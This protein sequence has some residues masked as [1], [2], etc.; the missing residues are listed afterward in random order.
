MLIIHY[1]LD[2]NMY[3]IT[4]QNI[5]HGQ[6]LKNETNSPVAIIIGSFIS[7]GV[8]P[9]NILGSHNYIAVSLAKYRKK[10]LPWGINFTDEFKDNIPGLIPIPE[11]NEWY[12]DN[13]ID[14]PKFLDYQ[15]ISNITNENDIDRTLITTDNYVYQDSKE[16]TNLIL[17][18]NKLFSAAN[19]CRSISFFNYNMDLPTI[20]VLSRIFQSRHIIDSLDPTLNEYPEL[21]VSNLFKSEIN[22]WSSSIID[23]THIWAIKSD[24][25]PEVQYMLGAS[26]VIPCYEIKC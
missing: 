19:Y 6:I 9:W 5:K 14:N 18:H 16:S 7:G 25:K 11:K 26:G 22:V 1:L 23:G 15:Y 8:N 2:L 10:G 3:N 4:S 17:N 24:G 21:G 13:Y 20:F 12:L